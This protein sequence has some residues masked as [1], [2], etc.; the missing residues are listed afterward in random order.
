MIRYGQKET[1]NERKNIVK[2]KIVIGY[3][4]QSQGKHIATELNRLLKPED[5]GVN[6][7]QTKKMEYKFSERN[8]TNKKERSI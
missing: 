6:K 7:A 1:K 4:Y 5:K 2:K 8:W 3:A